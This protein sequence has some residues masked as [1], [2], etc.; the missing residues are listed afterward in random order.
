MYRNATVCVVIPAFNEEEAIGWVLDETP[1]FVDYVVVVDDGSW[2]RTAEIAKAKGASVTSHGTNSGLGIAFQTG[3]R[4]ALQ[5]GADLMVNMDG[6]GQF[7]PRDISKLLEPIVDGDAEFV[8]AS[9]FL[10]RDLWPRMPKV[11]FVGNKVMARLISGL[12]GQ[13]FHDVSCGFRAY[14]RDTL[15]RLN[16]FGRFTYTQETFLEL[17]FKHVPIV[18][19]AVKVRGTREFGESRVASNLFRYGYQTIKIILN[20][21][22]DYRPFGLCFFLSAMIG[23]PGLCLSAFFISHYA[24][25][26]EF[27]PHK[28]AGFSAFALLFFAFLIL[29]LGFILDM[30]ARMRLNQ[31][32]IL[33]NLK[34]LG[35]EGKAG[36]S[37]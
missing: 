10:E 30:F 15:Y 28:W 2:D 29:G 24:L 37:N 22:R 6:D 17:G 36:E 7:N 14:S 3:L 33:Y 9:R 16:L 13:R 19:V 8:T 31:E 25:T 32:E 11:K 20:S 21:F 12:V 35:F 4:Q 27:T 26:G 23:L 5:L 34:R 18:E 1:D